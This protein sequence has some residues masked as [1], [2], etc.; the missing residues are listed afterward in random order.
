VYRLRLLC[1]PRAKRQKGT[2]G[3]LVRFQQIL[4]DAQK[5]PTHIDCV[6]QKQPTHIDCIAQKQPTH[7]DCI[8]LAE[9]KRVSGPVGRVVVGH[10]PHKRLVPRVVQLFGVGVGGRLGLQWV[11][12]LATTTTHKRNPESRSEFKHSTNIT[13]KTTKVENTQTIV[14]WPKR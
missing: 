8:A 6:A 1:L 4:R 14:G 9:G 7:I 3:T 13:K 2:T 11:E 12:S 5:Q 10:R